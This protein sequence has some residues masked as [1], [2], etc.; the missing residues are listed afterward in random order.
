MVEYNWTPNLCVSCQFKE[1]CKRCI[2]IRDRAIDVRSLLLYTSLW[3]LWLIFSRVVKASGTTENG[4]NLIA[5]NSYLD[6][7]EIP[8]SHEVFWRAMTTFLDELNAKF[9]R[10][11]KKK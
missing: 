2:H 4:F 6:G 9:I 10:N 7:I 3:E 5:M 11:K 8:V 1:T